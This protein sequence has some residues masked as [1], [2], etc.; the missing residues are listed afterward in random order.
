MKYHQ[1]TRICKKL[2]RQYKQKCHSYMW[3]EMADPGHPG[4]LGKCPTA[5][6][7]PD[8]DIFYQCAPPY[9]SNILKMVTPPSLHTMCVH[10]FLQ[11][12]K[13]QIRKF[14]FW[15]HYYGARVGHL[16]ELLRTN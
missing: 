1:Q 11:G 7:K 8:W 12:E 3:A 16:L 15:R 9:L 10:I 13:H 4:G 2:Q 6:V 14:L 5:D